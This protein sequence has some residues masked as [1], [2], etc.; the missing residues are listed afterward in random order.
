VSICTAAANFSPSYQC[1]GTTLVRPQSTGRNTAIALGFRRLRPLRGVCTG[2]LRRPSRPAAVILCRR[3]HELLSKA[4]SAVASRQCQC[5]L[6]SQALPLADCHLF[7]CQPEWALRVNLKLAS[8]CR[9]RLLLLVCQ[10]RS[11]TTIRRTARLG[12]LVLLLLVP[13]LQ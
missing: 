5:P 8:H 4:A 13:V 2:T 6:H 7:S 12:G 10:C 11:T 1:S 3:N 9:L